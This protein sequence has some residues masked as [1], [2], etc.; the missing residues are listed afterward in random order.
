MKTT[1]SAILGCALIIS[2]SG[3]EAQDWPQWRGPNRDAKVTGFKAPS[4]WPKELT[5]KWNQS[6]SIQRC[7]AQE[8]FSFAFRVSPIMVALGCL[9]LSP[10]IVQWRRHETW[11]LVANSPAV[12]LWPTAT[13][14]SNAT[15]CMTI[16]I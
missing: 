14:R 9:V 3:V 2:G 6:P 4:T 13:I 10:L 12:K 5:Q 1:L 8:A 11:R 15:S 16:A 7:V